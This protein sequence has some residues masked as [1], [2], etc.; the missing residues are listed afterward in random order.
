MIHDEE[1][2]V[3]TRPKP[4]AYKLGDTLIYDTQTRKTERGNI[5]K[6]AIGCDKGLMLARTI[7]ESIVIG[8]NIEV[9][10]VER[11]GNH[12]QLCIKAP[13]DVSIVRKELLANE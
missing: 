10:V 11:R 4:L 6:R 2:K 12:I 13:K 9:I 7:G 5:T 8:D 1:Q 3:Y